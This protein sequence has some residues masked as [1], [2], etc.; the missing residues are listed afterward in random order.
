MKTVDLI[1][2]PLEKKKKLKEKEKQKKQN[3][4]TQKQSR[5]QITTD[6][7]RKIKVL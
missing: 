6:K 2:F 5:A 7:H 1:T 3:N 4:N